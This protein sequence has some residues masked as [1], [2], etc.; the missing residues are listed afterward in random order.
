MIDKLLL[1][2][3]ICFF[4]FPFKSFC[5]PGGYYYADKKGDKIIEIVKIPEGETSK[6]K[7]HFDSAVVLSDS[8]KECSGVIYWNGLFWMHNDSG[9]E[10]LLFGVDL[11]GRI[12]RKIRVG[13]INRDWEDI[14]Q[15]SLY[16]YIGDFGNNAGARKDLKILKILKS[17][18]LQGTDL[19]MKPDII[20][21]SFPDQTSY[22]PANRKNNFDCE[23]VISLNDSLYLFSKDWLDGKTR[24]YRLPSQKG[25][26]TAQLYDSF[27][28]DGLITGAD[29][30]TDKQNIVL[31]GYKNYTPF[32]WILSGFN[33]DHFFA[34]K[35]NRFNF[36]IQ[37]GTQTEGIC[38]FNKNS[39][40]ITCEK[41]PVN[42]QKIFWFNI[43]KW[44]N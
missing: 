7:F 2:S 11:K 3:C 16:I 37:F 26:Y 8:L 25:I 41:S 10:P 18:I 20:S 17:A 23:A 4:L 33:Q 13:F 29:I 6:L 31:I 42:T 27:N 5:N 14:C 35:K 32:I 21:F 28:S 15:D 40:S 36:P 12:I 44:L 43:G 22:K 9:N 39:L 34:G 24:V 19:V 1:F 38:F 30:S